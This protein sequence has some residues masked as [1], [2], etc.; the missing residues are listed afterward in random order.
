MPAAKDNYPRTAANTVEL[1][2]DRTPGYAH[3]EGL[4]EASA[5]KTSE[6]LTVNHDLY[7][8]R[9]NAGLHNHIAHHLLALWSLGASPEEIQEMWEYNEPYQAPIHKGHPVNDLDL[10]D[11][12][13]FEECLGKDRHYVDFLVF[14]RGEVEKKG[15]PGTVREYVLKGDKR[16]NDI[17]ARMFSDLVHPMIHLGCGIEWD[18]PSIVAEA[19]AAACI[20]TNWPAELI[21]AP[22]EYLKEHEVRESPMLDILDQLRQD[23]AMSSAVKSTDPFN[24]IADGLMK[25]VSGQQFAPYLAQFQVKPTAEDIHNK[26][27]ENMHAGAYYMAAAQLPG[28]HEQ[29]DFVLL[30][31]VTLAGYYPAIIAQDWITNEEKA[32]LVEAKARVDIA[33]YPGVGCPTLYPERITNYQPDHPKDGWPELFRRAIVYRDEGHAVKLTRALF[34]LEKHFVDVGSATLPISKAD[35]MKIAHMSMDSIERAMEPGGSLVSEEKRNAV[36]KQV[37]HGYEFVLNNQTRWV[38]YNG[39][40]GAWNSVPALKN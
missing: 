28:K 5:R 2:P 31:N 30:H 38:F 6:L 32:R 18:Q 1:S 15:I 16:A 19:L 9:W 13:L 36:K 22:E 26:L 20:H 3:A 33:M 10:S 14:F 24:K 11:P 27:S 21:L 40:E 17:L 37:G 25:R 4:T 7:H 34:A 12:A 23:P 8:N 39:L 29:M 35:F